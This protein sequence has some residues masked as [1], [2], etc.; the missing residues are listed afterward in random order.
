LRKIINV[1]E[2]SSVS[3][4]CSLSEKLL[5]ELYNKAKRKLKLIKADVEFGEEDKSKIG[6]L[7]D[8]NMQLDNLIGKFD[9]L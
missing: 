9:R 1:N 7:D 3:R 8:I 5:D 2:A 4:Q 6:T